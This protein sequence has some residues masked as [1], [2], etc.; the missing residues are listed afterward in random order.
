MGE[1]IDW[2]DVNVWDKTF[3]NL[4]ADAQ[5]KRE[6][7]FIGIANRKHY[8]ASIALEHKEDALV[9]QKRKRKKKRK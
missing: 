3:M 7:G 4:L 8:L 1:V 6:M 5:R 9:S 2:E